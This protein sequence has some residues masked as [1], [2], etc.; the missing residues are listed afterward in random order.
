GP[1]KFTY[2]DTA[3]GSYK[4]ITTEA[5]TVN[6]SPA[7]A[8]PLPQNVPGAPVQFS[9]NLPPSTPAAAPAKPAVPP[10][11]PENLP[12]DP[13]TE[14]HRG[15]TPF[16]M[17]DLAVICITVATSLPLVAWLTLAALGSREYDPERR[18]REARA[19]LITLLAELRRSGS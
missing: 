17:R 12:R 6:V 1:V 7:T 15:L 13:L 18:R 14:A 3:S 8:T 10:A 19:A 4:T 5:V 11:P 9:L 16:G 2:F